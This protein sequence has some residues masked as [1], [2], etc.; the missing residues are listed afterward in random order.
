[1]VTE[2]LIINGVDIPLINGIATVLNYSIKD[3]E[4]PDKRKASFSKTIKLPQSKVTSDLFNFIF[5]IRIII[6]N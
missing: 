5:E 4:Q 1:M 6:Y 2:K 3:I